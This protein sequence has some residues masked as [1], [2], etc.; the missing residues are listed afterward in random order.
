MDWVLVRGT[1]FHL[2]KTYPSVSSLLV[3]PSKIQY[4]FNSSLLWSSVPGRRGQS[5]SI[6][7][8][9]PIDR[10]PFLPQHNSD[11]DK[12][13]ARRKTQSRPIE[14]KLVRE[15]GSVV[16]RYEKALKVP[17]ATPC[18]RQNLIAISTQESKLP[19]KLKRY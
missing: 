13:Y 17:V 6:P 9:S 12:A 14:R 1:S 16:G 8:L 2:P 10:S 7:I 11:T 18:P 4:K 15:V 19:Q 3:A 5:F